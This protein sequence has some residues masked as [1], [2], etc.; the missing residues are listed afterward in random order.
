MA[1]IIKTK[2]FSVNS[3]RNKIGHQLMSKNILWQWI[4]LSVAEEG[5]IF[6]DD[7]QHQFWK[8]LLLM[9]LFYASS[10]HSD[11]KPP[12]TRN[13]P[14]RTHSQASSYTCQASLT[15][16][17]TCVWNET[18]NQLYMIEFCVRSWRGWQ[19]NSAQRWTYCN[20]FF[21]GQTRYH[22][23]VCIIL[24]YSLRWITTV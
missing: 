13:V 23:Q 24:L 4:L 11:V 3:R 7:F 19:N 16:C 18:W 17:A 12:Y 9:L 10:S 22:K 5:L 20:T 2:S 15:L 8:M 21:Y 6:A 1:Q 14:N